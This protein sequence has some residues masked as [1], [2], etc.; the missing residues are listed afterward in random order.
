[1]KN[2]LKKGLLSVALLTAVVVNASEKVNVKVAKASKMLAIE[3]TKVAQGETL[4]IKD[5]RGEILFSEKLNKSDKFSKI[6]S[7]STLPE[8]LYFVESKETSKVVVTPIIINNEGVALVENA[9][10]TY[11]A[12]T[13]KLEGDILN[14]KVRNYTNAPV[15]ITIYNEKGLLLTKTKNNTNTLVFGSFNIEELEEKNLTVSVSEGDY[16]FIEKVKL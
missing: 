1:M 11:L 8:G 12:P 2:V 6:F 4:T 16:N 15:N 3:L 14:V 9:A 7:L 13:I 5:L 10:K